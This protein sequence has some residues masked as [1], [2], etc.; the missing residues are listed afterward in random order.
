MLVM[1]EWLCARLHT[2]TCI[3]VTL[4]WLYARLRTCTCMLVTLEWLC[5][6]L[7]TCTCMLV[8]LEWLCARLRTC[9]C[10]LVTL[11]RLCAG[12]RVPGHTPASADAVHR[13]LSLPTSR[14]AAGPVAQTPPAASVSSAGGQHCFLLGVGLKVGEGYM[15]CHHFMSW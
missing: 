8:T 14:A 5:A 3:L 13:M 4:E 12:L 1:L 11:E 9:T 15:R 7:L 6:R 2:C 10:M